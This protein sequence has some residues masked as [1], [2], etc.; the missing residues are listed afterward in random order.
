MRNLRPPTHVTHVCV[1]V[2]TSG[3]ANIY[4]CTFVCIVSQ[5]RWRY[6][7]QFIFSRSR[8]LP[9]IYVNIAADMCFPIKF[10]KN[11]VL[12]GHERACVIARDLRYSRTK[13]NINCHQVYVQCN[14]KF[15]LTNKR[16]SNHMW[17]MPMYFFCS[18]ARL[19][20]YHLTRRMLRNTTPN[21][22][23]AQPLVWASSEALI[24]L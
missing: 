15:A 18:F 20:R 3:R 9:R 10:H 14:I 5:C 19:I 12:F 22:Q 2:Y 23:T 17:P 1:C 4:R 13:T 6:Q 7:F 21:H 24:L 16:V 8:A 11:A